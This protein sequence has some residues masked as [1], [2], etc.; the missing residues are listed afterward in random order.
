MTKK[1]DDKLLT[2]SK[3]QANLRSKRIDYAAFLTGNHL[4]LPPINNVLVS[5]PPQE[6]VDIKNTPKPKK[7]VEL[8]RL[9]ETHSNKINS[10]ELN[11]IIFANPNKSR[12]TFQRTFFRSSIYYTIDQRKGR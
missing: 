9:L 7:I 12:M 4:D 11:R 3:M 1:I 6:K 10:E 2:I 5:F 8:E